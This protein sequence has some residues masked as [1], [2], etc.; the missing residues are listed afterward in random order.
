M[1]I[2]CICTEA[3]LTEVYMFDCILKECDINWM[4]M[5]YGKAKGRHNL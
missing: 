2:P 1:I 3:A 4:I 5:V